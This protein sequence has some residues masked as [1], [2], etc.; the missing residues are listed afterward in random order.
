MQIA[1]LAWEAATNDNVGI[2]SAWA[3]L[4]KSQLYKAKPDKLPMFVT[5]LRHLHFP[6]L[7]EQKHMPAHFAFQTLRLRGALA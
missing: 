6:Q 2:V 7:Y 3:G 1:R 5:I 4:A